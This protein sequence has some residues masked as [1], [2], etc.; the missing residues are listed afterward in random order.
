MTLIQSWRW[1]G[2]NDPVS[3]RDIEQAGA[4]DVVSALHYIP[5][6]EVW[7]LEDILKRKALIQSAGLKWSIVESV[8]VHEAI[9]TRNDESEYYI[10][11]YIQTLKNLS[12]AGLKLVCYNFM[13]VLDWTRTDL[14]YSLPN[15]A[16]ALYFDWSDLAAFDHFIL[17]R[18]NAFT[19]YSEEI[20][21]SA[22]GRWT[23]MSEARKKE[24]SDIVLMGVPTE[25]SMPKEDLMKSISIYEQIGKSGLRDNLVYFLKSIQQTCE[26]EEITMTI[27]PD[28]P[29]YPILG[30]PRIASDE[31]D[32]LY[33]INKVPESFNGICFCTGSLGA[34]KHNVLP[35]IL[36]KVGAK[37]HFAHLRNVKKN[38]KGDF[39]E[40]EHLDGDVDMATIM[41][42]LIILNKNRERPIFYRPDHG[43]QI[44]DDLK[45]ETN[46]GY[47]AIGRLKGLAE[48]RGL[49]I[50]LDR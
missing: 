15:G 49:E 38:S 40:A 27:H 50:G 3:L 46:P 22:K 18:K 6:G 12:K 9:K 25:K 23:G 41:E 42:Q 29:P 8:P 19:F 32:L 26:E 20:V 35:E 2:P 43:H 16:K 1:F 30:L 33:I 34:G 36:A 17:Q 24:L 14:S 21:A 5:H 45:K 37:V 13:P 31:E 44:L 48:L 4:T 39:Y 10:E 47:S 7:P 28:D 11:N